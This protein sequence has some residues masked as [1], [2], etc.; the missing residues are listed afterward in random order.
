MVIGVIGNVVVDLSYDVPA[1]PRA[2]ETLVASGMVLD[3]GGKGFN[4]AIVSRRS[5]SHVHLIAAIGNDTEGRLIKDKVSDYGFE[6]AVLVLQEGAS[7]RSIIYVADTGKNC[8]VSTTERALSLTVDDVEPMLERLTPADTLLLQGNLTLEMTGTL[9][10]LARSRGVRTIV[11]PA[12]ITF[13]YRKL[14]PLIDVAIVNEVEGEILTG[15]DE[16]EA[17]AEGMLAFG[18]QLV[19]VTLGQ[20][21]V[22]FRDSSQSRRI[23]APSVQAVDSTGA[24]DVFCGVFAAALDQGL[25]IEPA[26]RW[27][28]AAASL[29]VTRR[30]TLTAFPTDREIGNLKPT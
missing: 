2:G 8:I 11:N 24:G 5:G 12:P 25:P 10:R 23:E 6:R 21:G 7:D 13:D 26:C 29:S 1:L 27:A 9:L 22:L 20:D 19:L 17:V 18:V 16:V 4:Q 14:W 28:V 3:V 30:G 15:V